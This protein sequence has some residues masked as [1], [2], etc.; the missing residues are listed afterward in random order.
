[1]KKIASLVVL[2]SW[3]GCSDEPAVAVRDDAGATET[4]AGACVA[5][6][7]REMC[8]RLAYVCGALSAD[9]NCGDSREI[10][11]CGDEASVCGDFA[12]CGGGGVTG[13]CG[14]IPESDEELCV[15]EGAEC[16]ALSTTDR[17]GQVREIASCG[18]ATIVCDAV[19]TCGGAGEPGVCGCAETDAEMC[20]RAGYVC[21]ELI[22]TDKCGLDRTIASCGDEALV[23]SAFETCAGGGIAG[24]CG[25]SAK[26]DVQLCAENNYLC[27]ELQIMDNCGTARVISCTPDCICGDGICA[28]PVETV[29]TCPVDC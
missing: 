12:T 20:T 29:L 8:E 18:D 7:D 24:E 4:D 3:I 1:M 26:S 23:C 15:A 14:C 28:P 10:P 11:S 21:G 9:D 27:G 16:G 2:L 13:A 19:E 22:G 25:C 6:T 17:C 5:E